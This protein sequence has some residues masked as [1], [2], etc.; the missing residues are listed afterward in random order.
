MLSPLNSHILLCNKISSKP[1]S[2][3][4][5]RLSF[6]HHMVGILCIWLKITHYFSL[7]NTFIFKWDFSIHF[8]LNKFQLLTAINTCRY[9][10]QI[11]FVHNVYLRNHCDP[12]FI[13]KQYKQRKITL[14]KFQHTKMYAINSLFTILQSSSQSVYHWFKT[15]RNIYIKLF[16][17]LV[18]HLM[19][20]ESNK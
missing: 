6:F 5:G 17:F 10:N 15:T 12:S 14:Y 2:R 13:H 16:L 9:K 8:F 7:T 20:D 19:D 4:S 11:T 18:T 1:Q 3:H